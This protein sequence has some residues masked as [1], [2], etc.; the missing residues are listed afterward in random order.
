MKSW[1]VDNSNRLKKIIGKLS[2]EDGKYI[3]RIIYRDPF[4]DIY[5]I[6]LILYVF[7]LGG[8]LLWP[9]DF[10]SSVRN[11]ARWIGN[12]KGIEFLKTGQAVSNSSTQEFF[13]RLVKG[14]GLTVEL[15]LQTEDIN[16]SGPARILSYSK[17]TDFRNFTIGQS[18]DQL[19]VRLHTTETSPNG[20][21]PHLIIED[22]FNYKGLQHMVIVYDFLEQR[23]YINGEQKARSEI[24]KG[25]FSNWDPSYSLAIGNEVTGNR[26]WKGK[27]YYVAV[28]NRPLTEREI[29]QSYISGLR[30]KINEGSTKHAGFKTKDPVTRYL[31]DEGKENLIHDSGTVL[32]SV[33]LFMPNYVRHK[34]KPF[35]GFSISSLQ[36]KSLFLDIIINML[37]FIPLGILIH[38]MLRTCYGLTLKIS[39]AALLTGTLFTLGVELIQYF[40]MT[41]HSSL[42]DVFTNMTGTAI[43]IFIDRIYNLFLNYQAKRLRMLMYERTE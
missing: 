4:T 8:F 17:D 5:S 25:D 42:I 31:F 24:L 11:D 9:F 10:V 20:T 38:G 16:Q 33:N 23:V 37:I 19:V 1:T 22:V 40:S 6:L 14:S 15:W 7:L 43:G 32:N 41:R 2:T 39:L 26:P 29:H 21:N 3:C 34:T 28:F 36:S 18:R 12:S 35:L 13:D 27:I 30:L